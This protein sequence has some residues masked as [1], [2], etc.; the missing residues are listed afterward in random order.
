MIEV[1]NI[2]KSFG[3]HLVLNNIS[4]KIPEGARTCIV[5]KSGSGKSVLTKCMLGLLPQDHGE[6][7]IDGMSTAGY[8]QK[9]WAGL[10]SHFGVVFQGAA[11]FDSL[12]V[13][14]NVGIAL[15][16]NRKYSRDYIRKMV[17]NALARVDLK[18]GI[19]EKY[20]NQLSG[21]MR[22]RVGISRAIIHN[23]KYLIWD[24]PSTGLDPVNSTMIDNLI[25]DLAEFEGRT[26]IIITHDMATVRNIAT[27]VAMIQDTR[28]LFDG[29]V[30][31]FLASDH[32]DILAFLERG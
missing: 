9:D 17:V 16:E 15:F 5:G 30:A 27:R 3:D 2:Y 11:L 23:P 25:R 29:E 7:I 19:L 26:S 18:P 14:E 31:D 13:L 6:V 12:T 10:L 21:G 32:P 1:R 20:P 8:R 28:L 22:K 4:L 24:E